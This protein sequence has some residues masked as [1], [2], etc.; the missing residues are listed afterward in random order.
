MLPNLS[1]LAL[2]PSHWVWP[3]LDANAD[4]SIRLIHWAACCDFFTAFFLPITTLRFRVQGLGYDPFWPS[5]LLR[6]DLK[7]TSSTTQHSALDQTQLTRLR[8]GPKREKD[9]KPHIALLHVCANVCVS[10]KYV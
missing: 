8:P 1:S 4:S 3:R 9:C 6:Y 2:H 7:P 10:L 5:E